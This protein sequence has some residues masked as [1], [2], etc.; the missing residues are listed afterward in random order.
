MKHE[1]KTR[2]MGWG[3]LHDLH[4]D[5]WGSPIATLTVDA[6]GAFGEPGPPSINWSATGSQAIATTKAFATGLLE[7]AALADSYS[8]DAGS[9]SKNT[10]G[11]QP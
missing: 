10:K 2:E 7:L 6:R 11:L 5:G 1:I 3:T 9:D 4:M 8:K